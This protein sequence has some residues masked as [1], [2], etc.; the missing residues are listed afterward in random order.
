MSKLY[1][2]TSSSKEISIGLEI[3]YEKDVMVHKVDA[4]KAQIVLPLID[5]L[6]KKHKMR[7]R[8][9]SE[10]KVNEGPGS[11]TGL[12]VGVAIANT[13]GGWLKIPV[14]GKPVGEILEPVYQ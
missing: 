9:I 7:I 6:L 13:L 10:I 2:D 3:D 1:I 14:N 12:R 8:D 5:E 4:W 11:F